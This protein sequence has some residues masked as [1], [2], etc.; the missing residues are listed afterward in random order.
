VV[1]AVFSALILFLTSVADPNKTF[2]MYAWLMGTLTGPDYVTLILLG[3]YLLLGLGLL[4]SKAQALNLLTLGEETARSLGVEVEHVKKLV[5]LMSALVTGA[6][7]AFS[8]LIGFV[9][10]I[11]PH[12]IRLGVSADHR[13]LMPLS[14]VV[15]GALLMVADAVARTLLSPIELPVGVVTALVGG[16]VFLYLLMQRRVGRIG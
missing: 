8:G 2:G 13:L 1:T 9:G 4:G 10:L 3:G 15:G 14:G 12:A 5:F 7:V 6:A 11:V 16:P